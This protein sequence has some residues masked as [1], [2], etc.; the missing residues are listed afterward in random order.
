MHPIPKWIL[1]GT[2]AL[3]LWGPIAASVAQGLP[4]GGGLLPPVRRGADGQIEIAPPDPA[5]GPQIGRHHPAPA[6]TPPKAGQ[7]A[8]TRR[9][10]AP[11]MRGAAAPPEPVITVVPTTP[12]V[13]DNTPRGAA[14]A[15]YSVTMSDGSPFTGTVRFGAPYYDGKGA[16]ALSGKNIIVN[17]NGPGLG[18]NKTTI[19]NHITLEAIP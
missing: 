9:T 6:A 11:A 12:K 10:A 5:A 15:T 1:L 19:T 8:V 4:P 3:L 16:F 7:P 18:T 13:P 2:V 14:V 17:P